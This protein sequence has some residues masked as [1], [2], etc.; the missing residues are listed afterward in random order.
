[1]RCPQTRAS[2]LA[3]SVQYMMTTPPQFIRTSPTL[4][5][6]SNAKPRT[7]PCSPLPLTVIN[8]QKPTD[9]GCVVSASPAVQTTATTPTTL[10][11]ATQA[12]SSLTD[13]LCQLIV[14]TANPLC[15]IDLAML[16]S[17]SKSSRVP[18]RK[19]SRVRTSVTLLSR[20]A[21]R[22]LASDVLR[23]SG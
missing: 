14:R 3:S 19:S 13:L 7:S 1:M 12:K 17:M 18:T 21:R 6:K 4:S 8:A 9:N 10:P 16:S 11:C 5:S 22:R 20:I 15:Q 23:V 2:A